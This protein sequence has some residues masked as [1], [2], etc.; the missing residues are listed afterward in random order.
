MIQLMEAWT[1]RR[2][3]GREWGRN[4]T[5]DASEGDG[6]QVTRKIESREHSIMEAEERVQLINDPEAG[7]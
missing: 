4:G 5:K 6:G 3:E 7:H 1:K 2:K